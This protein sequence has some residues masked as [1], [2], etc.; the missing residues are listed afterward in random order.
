MLKFCL[1]VS[2]FQKP[3]TFLRLAFLFGTKRVT[4][5]YSESLQNEVLSR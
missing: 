5:R 4:D 2:I 3:A 1:R